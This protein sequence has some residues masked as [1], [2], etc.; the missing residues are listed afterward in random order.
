MQEILDGRPPLPADLEEK[1]LKYGMP[2][3]GYLF[4]RA[5][6][7]VNPLTGEPQK[8]GGMLLHSLQNFFLDGICSE[9]RGMGYLPELWQPFPSAEM[10]RFQDV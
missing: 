1:I 3:S 2:W 4:I 7:R 9:A 6:K 10:E 5:A 8:G